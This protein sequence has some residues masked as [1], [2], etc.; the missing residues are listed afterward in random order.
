MDDAVSAPWDGLG[1]AAGG[2]RA[3]FVRGWLFGA[4]CLGALS[5][6]GFEVNV[7]CCNCSWWEGVSDHLFISHG[8]ISS[9]LTDNDFQPSLIKVSLDPTLKLSMF[10]K[11]S[12][13]VFI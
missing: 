12:S 5:D 2:C 1:R 10:H 9:L 7:L 6:S 13:R 4:G 8:V 11:C 3:G